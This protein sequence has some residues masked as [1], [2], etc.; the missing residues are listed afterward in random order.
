M[1]VSFSVRAAYFALFATLVIGGYLM[2]TPPVP[3]SLA[4]HDF[5]DQRPLFGIP[6]MLNVGSNLPFLL[7][8]LW[9]LAF[10]A[11]KG[12]RRRGIFLEEAER[13]PYRMFFLAL[14]LT[15]FGS[16]WYHANPNSETLVWDRLP[17][18]V[19][20]M[21]LFSAILAERL[22]WQLAT[23]LLVP[24]VALAVDGVLYWQWTD[25]LRFYF[26]IQ[27]F[28]MLALPLLLLCFAPRY[29]GTGAL[30]AALACYA[31]AKVLELF[32]D[33]IYS[34]LDGLVS[35]HTLKHLLAGVAA[36]L[37]L[38]MLRRRQ[39]WANEPEPNARLAC[40]RPATSTPAPRA[41]R[42]PP[43]RG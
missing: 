36:Y 27:F 34:A 40:P 39:A 3:Q 8:G 33:S 6:H 22:G 20:F 28:P 38:V 37:V 21:A 13:W 19:T 16:A 41:S 24:L 26:V 11:G 15:A 25:D 30:L 10:I 31:F 1:K 17:L 35:G 18:A 9:G 42:L 32:D 12:S 4:Y 29:T 5:A 23:W 14:A 7:V 43:L 2:F